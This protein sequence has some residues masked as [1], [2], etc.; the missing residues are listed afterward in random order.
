MSSLIFFQCKQNMDILIQ[1]ALLEL[2]SYGNIFKQ[3]VNIYK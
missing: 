2:V 3:Y 1:L